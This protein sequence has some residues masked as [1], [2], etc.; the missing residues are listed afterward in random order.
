MHPWLGASC[1]LPAS[2][3]QPTH[4]LSGACWRP[5]HGALCACTHLHV[6]V[7][8][9]CVHVGCVAVQAGAAFLPSCLVQPE[10]FGGSGLL[11]GAVFSAGR[12]AGRGGEHRCVPGH[13]ALSCEHSVLGLGP[14]PLFLWIQEVWAWPL[15][16]PVCTPTVSHRLC[17]QAPQQAQLGGD[18]AGDPGRRRGGRE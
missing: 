8:W 11:P 4:R 1:R 5:L 7:S 12:A 14:A 15:M 17:E 9:V 6:Q 18:G 10:L 16:H 2:R 3:G 13:Q